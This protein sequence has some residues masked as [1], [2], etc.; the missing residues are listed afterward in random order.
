MHFD[1]IHLQGRGKRKIYII[2]HEEFYIYNIIDYIQM[3][4]QGSEI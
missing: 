4:I 3:I 2:L 1:L